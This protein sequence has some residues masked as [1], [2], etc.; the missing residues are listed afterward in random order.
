MGIWMKEVTGGTVTIDS[1]GVTYFNQI[2]PNMLLFKGTSSGSGGNGKIQQDVALQANK[3]YKLSFNFKAVGTGLEGEKLGAELQYKQ[4]SS[5]VALTSTKAE[6]DTEYRET[7]EF[8][9]PSDVGSGSNFRLMF[10]ASSAYTSGYAANF[11]LYEVDA[12]GNIVGENL[13]SNGDFA[14]GNAAYWAKSGAYYHFEF[15]EIPE[16]FFSKLTSHKKKMFIY[17]NATDYA[18]LSYSPQL[19]PATKYELTYQSVHTKFEKGK[20]STVPVWLF[21]TDEEGKNVDN[22]TKLEK[23]T[24]GATT[25]SYFT[26]PETLRTKSNNN[27][28]IRLY[29][30]SGN[31]GYWS[32]IE[33]YELDEDGNRVSNNLVL[34]NDFSSGTKCWDKLGDFNMRFVEEPEGFFD[35]WH[36]PTEMITSHGTHENEIY[37]QNLKVD[38]EKTYVFTGKYVNMNSEGINPQVQYLPRSAKGTNNYKDLPI[39]LYYDTDRY[40]FEVEFEIPDDA[41]VTEGLAD[42]RV[43]I[44]NKNKGKGYFTDIML[45][46][47][48]KYINLLTNPTYSN[49][50]NYE[51]VKYDPDVFVFYYD[52]E[53][54]NDGD[55]SGE[56]EN[57]KYNIKYGTVTGRIVDQDGNGVAGVKMQ[58]NPGKITVETDKDGNY[59]FDKVDPG[60]YKLYL[61]DKKDSIYCTDVTVQKGIWSMMPLITFIES[62][63]FTSEVQVD[64]EDSTTED[65]ET[66]DYG[67]LRGFYYDRK[68]NIIKGAT[69]HLRGVG[70]SV[71]DDKG[72]FMFDKVP[73]GTH[74]LYTVLEDG[75][76]YVLRE[77]VIEANK[78]IQVKVMEPAAKQQGNGVPWVMILIVSGAVFVCAGITLAVILLIKK[79]K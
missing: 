54:F 64:G 1:V 25:Y 44:N 35:N 57:S 68:G 43:L 11:T 19:K 4:G 39:E 55:W 50:G 65:G 15:S 32:E 60:E 70:S 14:T 37:G 2:V 58:L 21:Y 10:H 30:R 46:E 75:S 18:Q 72:M 76:E 48:D 6:S 3:K 13:I 7:Y 66:E 5:F 23:V 41:L 67:M 9:M 20:E 17:S 47:S 62:K 52:D 29:M 16:N 73:V 56:W 24:D 61:L 45:F 12:S 63:T 59:S 26:T 28:I 38:A 49:S 27:A 71:T 74:E 22:S 33:L 77:V 34:N 8:T 42:I 40:Y 78:G 69:I 36:E 51:K 79:K 31:A 53:K